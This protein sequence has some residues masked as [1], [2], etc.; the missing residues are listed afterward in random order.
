M[1]T[2]SGSPGLPVACRSP[3]SRAPNIARF[4]KIKLTGHI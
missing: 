2:V 4:D 1:L 3:T